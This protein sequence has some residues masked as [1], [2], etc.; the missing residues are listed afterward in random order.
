V[1][2]ESRVPSGARGTFVAFATAP[3]QM[4]LD[5]EGDHSVYT[6][7]LLRHI[8]TPGLGIEDVFKRVR[9]D[10]SSYTKG[11]Q[12]PKEETGL[13]G[14]FYFAGQ[15]GGSSSAPPP[16]APCPAGTHPDPGGTRC[17]PLVVIDCPA[18]TRFEAGTGCVAEVQV[19]RNEGRYA[20]EHQRSPRE[21]IRATIDHWARAQRER[22]FTGY[23]G[24]YASD[25]Q[26]IKRTHRGAVK[27]YD[28]DGWLQD[29]RS[30]FK[31]GLGVWTRQLRFLEHDAWRAT[32][33][34]IQYWRS[35]KYADQGKKRIKLVKRGEA[36]R[37]INE[38]MITSSPWSGELPR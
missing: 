33:V 12:L 26:G 21:A 38:E 11:G 20:N 35:K 15:E 17:Q 32:V 8:E 2:F 1:G 36:W 30:M 27:R 37:I 9:A 10:V 16:Q 22:D 34:F 19:A 7:A 18:G 14:D 23:G 6:R 3:R 4:A 31:P 24:L 5:G 25:F 13:V 28:R 29:R